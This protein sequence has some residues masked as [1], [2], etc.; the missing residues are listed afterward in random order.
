MAGSSAGPWARITKNPV[1]WWEPEYWIKG[2]GVLLL[3]NTSDYSG[4]V[5]C[6]H[7]RVFAVDEDGNES[8]PAYARKSLQGECG[9][10]PLPP[11]PS[12]LRN[13]VASTA[14][15]ITGDSC[16]TELVWDEFDYGSADP[17]QQTALSCS[18]QEPGW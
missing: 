14:G 9:E 8:E 1:A 6:L 17:R 7:F 16:A 3:M 2:A 4:S 13:L 18:G 12:A 5:E 11:T 15:G 10:E